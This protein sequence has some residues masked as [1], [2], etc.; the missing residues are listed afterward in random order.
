[1][2]IWQLKL[3]CIILFLACWHHC[4]CETIKLTVKSKSNVINIKLIAI[5]FEIDQF[6]R[7]LPF[8]I[9]Y[10][11]R[12]RCLMRMNLLRRGL[13]CRRHW[14]ANKI[15]VLLILS[16]QQRR[17]GLRQHK[18]ISLK[19]LKGSPGSHLPYRLTAMNF[20]Y[21]MTWSTLT[22][23][24]QNALLGNKHSYCSWYRGERA[25]TIAHV[26]RDNNS[27]SVLAALLIFPAPSSSY[28]S[29][30]V[31]FSALRRT[32]KTLS[33]ISPL[34]RWTKASGGHRM[35]IFSLVEFGW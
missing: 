7:F 29:M 31:D 30:P 26:A 8:Y 10:T 17:V 12:Y 23:A 2:N 35:V 20:P 14:E 34:Y 1:M 15:S 25:I 27:T 33:L 16:K 32:E 9:H 22:R 11:D 28:L 6:K 4:G 19:P 24:N 21:F 18:Q 13:R 3:L 5:K